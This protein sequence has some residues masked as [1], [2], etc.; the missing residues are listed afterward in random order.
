M[1]RRTPQIESAGLL[2]GTAD[3]IHLK[4]RGGP[5]T[6]CRNSRPLGAFAQR[7]WWRRVRNR[8][9]A[10]AVGQLAV[11]GQGEHGPARSPPGRKARVGIPFTHRAL[12]FLLK[13]EKCAGPD[14]L[15]HQQVSI[16]CPMSMA[17]TWRSAAAAR[18]GLGGWQS[19]RPGRKRRHLA[20]QSHW[21][22]PKNSQKDRSKNGSHREASNGLA[23][24]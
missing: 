7:R 3:Q 1:P 22:P 20:T 8:F 15:L 13:R 14:Q 12:I 18:E 2:S 5:C 19:S 6:I 24:H 10:M 23:P 16:W 9:G 21:Q 4:G 17:A 11:N